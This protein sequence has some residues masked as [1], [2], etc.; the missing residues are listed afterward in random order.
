[1]KKILILLVCIA[2]VSCKHVK[3]IVEVPIEV[4]STE[5]KT[6]YIHDTTHT[7]DST[8]IFING[9]T[10]YK[11]HIRTIYVGKTVH[12]SLVTHDTI[13]QI[14]NTETVVTEIVNKPQWWP[15][16]L[17][18][19]IVLLYLLITKTKFIEIIKNFIKIIIKLFK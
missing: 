8:I 12:D 10:V 6:E 9:D 16:W 17:S 5:Y 4:I 13:P 3:E 1:M 11:E 2:F 18:L 15:V 7:T 14:V 19:G